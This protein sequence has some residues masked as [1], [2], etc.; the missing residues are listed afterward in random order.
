MTFTS[1]AA[2]SW[3]NL[4]SELARWLRLRAS[5]RAARNREASP[6]DG[7]AF[8]LRRVRATLDFMASTIVNETPEDASVV[9]LT[10]RAYRWA[11]RIARELEAI[12]KLEMDALT[13]WARFEAFAPFAL[14]FF[15][16]L[17][18]APLYDATT[19][20]DVARVRRDV[21][22]VLAPLSVAMTSSAMAA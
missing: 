4:D 12:E 3:D 7:T 10:S 13:E 11:I 20:A 5:R 15:D 19:S 1:S 17:L 18:A 16:S 8:A 22:A 21:D 9:V 2:T 14:A 6:L